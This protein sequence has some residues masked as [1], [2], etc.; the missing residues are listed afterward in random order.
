MRVARYILLRLKLS[1]CNLTCG[2]ANE[3]TFSICDYILQGY[4]YAY[5]YKRIILEERIICVVFKRGVEE[6]SKK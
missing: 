3:I 4:E 1:Y 2:V 6:W 5:L